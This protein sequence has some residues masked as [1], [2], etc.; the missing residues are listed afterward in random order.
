MLLARPAAAQ[1]ADLDAAGEAAQAT[2]GNAPAAENPW[3]RRPECAS[4]FLKSDWRLS[5]RQKACDWIH[6]RVL[7]NSALFGALGSAA[8]SKVRDSD[9]EAGDGFRIRFGRRFAQSTFKSTGAYLGGLVARE[10]PRTVPP[11]LI[12]KSS[13]R[14]RGFLARTRHALANNLMSYACVGDCRS[15]ADIRRRLALSR[16]V[17][18]LASGYGGEVW[19]WDRETSHQRAL[20]GAASAYGSSFVDALYTEFK[21][22]LTAA[23]GKVF[24]GLF[25]FK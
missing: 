17:G 8:V 14:P 2:G 13:P 15:E 1:P 3:E 11:Y 20:R 18:A 24:G 21:P 10:D 7:S 16:V 6:N 12:M 22:E 5:G 19:T 4:M 25:G 9:S 23:A